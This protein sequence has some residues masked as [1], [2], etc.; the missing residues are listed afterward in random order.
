[1]RANYYDCD[2]NN[3]LKISAAMRYMQQTS[4]EHLEALDLSPA[5]LY[6]ENM[7]FLLTKMCIKIHRMPAAAETLILGTAPT[8]IKGPRFARE[9]VMNSPEGERLISA[10]SLWIL[11][12]PKT[13]KI[14][15]PASFLHPLPIQ[16]TIIGGAIDDIGFPK[17]PETGEFHKTGVQIRYS[18][19]DTN[20]HVNN[21][22][23]ADFVCD[24]LPYDELMK[25][26]LDMLVIGFHSEA[27]HGDFVEIT[28]CAPAE[29][30]YH[31]LGRHGGSLC[32]EALAILK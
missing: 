12:D 14:L 10:L 25:S 20:N 22:V 23:Y 2:A 4:S 21:S 19:L 18:H 5:K 13:R 29:K 15:R 26:E 9:F 24:A 1:M 31:V 17:L 30:E 28:T 6:S 3:L 16:P 7:V 8:E 32:F 27:R 11:V